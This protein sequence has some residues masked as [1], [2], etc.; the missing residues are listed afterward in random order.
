M[1]KNTKKDKEQISVDERL[2]A[3][4]ETKFGTL[5]D[6]AALVLLAE[7][8]HLEVLQSELVTR[9]KEEEAREQER[10]RIEQE[11]A[12]RHNDVARKKEELTQAIE[13]LNQSISPDKTDNELLTF[14]KQRKALEKELDAL[15]LTPDVSETP[16]VE[17]TPEPVPLTLGAE[18]ENSV[19]GEDEPKIGV[20]EV[21]VVS[22][23]V[24]T[25]PV[26]EAKKEEVKEVKEEI[27][28][29]SSF[30]GTLKEDFGREGIQDNDLTEGSE[31]HRYLDQLKNNIGSLGTLL[32]EMP[33]N[34]KKNKDF[35]LKVAEI[36]P[37]YA[38]HY[39]DAAT[40]KHDEDFNIRIASMK[41]PRNSGNALVEMLPEARTS[42]VVLAAVKHDYR[43]V[44]FIQPNMEAYDEIL[45][46]AK[47]A[48]L[49]KVKEL[50]E[51]ADMRLI[52]PRLL[53]EDK[54][55]IEEVE[56]AISRKG[57]EETITQP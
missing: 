53:Q 34:A 30:K 29:P 2:A 27:L 50:K 56:K 48:T 3:I 42:R 31:L 43:N 39:A 11:N 22:P 38:M 35:M 14:V 6:E 45:R 17:P 1:A 12:K 7:R 5:S 18:S 16:S 54:R 44:R 51:A 37:A 28:E 4:A 32:Q 8:K 25:F 36:D 21:D 47:N 40:L 26:T 55:F 57:G 13:T 9:Q 10:L 52:V 23:E 19:S 33:A 20:P 15:S 46:I 41:N 24:K 49:E